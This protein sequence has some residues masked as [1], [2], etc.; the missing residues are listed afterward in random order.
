M[1][2]TKPWGCYGDL[3]VAPKRGPRKQVNVR[4]KA[5]YFA[6]DTVDAMEIKQSRGAWSRRAAMPLGS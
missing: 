2:R 4:P 6:G 1:I 3:I 5:K